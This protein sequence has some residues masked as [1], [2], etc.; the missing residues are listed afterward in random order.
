MLL[1]VLDISF[2]IAYP[3]DPTDEIL[4]GAADILICLKGLLIM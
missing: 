3:A 4:T 2:Q 1:F